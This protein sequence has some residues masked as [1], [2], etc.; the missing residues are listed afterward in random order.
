MTID[1]PQ[2]FGTYVISSPTHFVG[3]LKTDKFRI[4]HLW[5][6]LSDRNALEEK[7]QNAPTYRHRFVVSV[8]LK[9]NELDDRSKNLVSQQHIA[10]QIA[11]LASVWYGKSFSS[12]GALLER[13]MFF[14]P[15]NQGV[16]PAYYRSVPTFDNKP[17]KD[18]NIAL[19]WTN[20]A[21]PLP[22]LDVRPTNTDQLS[23]FWNAARFYRSAL[24]YFEIDPEVSF[25]LLISALECLGG[26]SQLPEH[27][28]FDLDLLKDLTTIE[29]TADGGKE[30]VGRLKGRLYQVRRRIGWLT[31]TYLNATFF[32]GSESQQAFAALAPDDF[33]KVILDAYDLRSRYAHKGAIF[34]LL[35]EPMLQ[36][37]NEK[38]VGNTAMIQGDQLAATL[39]KGSLTFLGLERL[40]RFIIVAFCHN[41][42]LKLDDRL[43]TA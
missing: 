25:F 28:L 15:R 5:P 41:H 31:T 24:N 9:E 12:L 26:F 30:I 20:F 42:I 14:L 37:N 21:Q 3:D 18:L 13:G 10:Q 1:Y 40:T 4:D 38:L 2:H 36:L 11:T 7:F 16:A 23:A 39:P 29:R 33:P 19:K 27:E 34:G 17:R 22:I 32:E 8:L 6:D 43:S 35:I